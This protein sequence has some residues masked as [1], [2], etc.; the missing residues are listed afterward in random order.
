MLSSSLNRRL[1]SSFC[2]MASFSSWRG[3]KMHGRRDILTSLLK[4]RWAYD[5]LVVGDCNGHGQLPGT[6]PTDSPDALNAGLDMYMAPDSWRGLRESLLRQIQDGTVPLKRLNEAVRAVL[7]L[8]LRAG[9]FS[10][11]KPSARLHGGDF[12]LL[13]CDAHT[14]LAREAVRKSAVLLKNAGGA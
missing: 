10:Q 13:G 14:E 6:T 7:R 2:L 4:E 5:G 11:P 9:L 3:R 1:I 12:S 8:K